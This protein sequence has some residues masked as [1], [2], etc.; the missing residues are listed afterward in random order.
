VSA[1]RIYHTSVSARR[2]QGAS[3]HCPSWRQ[4]LS[5]SICTTARQGRPCCLYFSYGDI[6]I[7]RGLET[8][9]RSHSWSEFE[10]RSVF[11]FFHYIIILGFGLHWEVSGVPHQFDPFH[12]HSFR[13][14]P[15]WL[16]QCPTW[17][18][19]PNPVYTWFPERPLKNTNLTTS[20]PPLNPSVRA[21]NG[22]Q[23]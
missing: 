4:A 7:Q 16:P 11:C 3:V 9:Q 12:L 17:P 23:Q 15:R 13:S 8:C 14:G 6:E 2:K 10:L 21:G 18:L 20:H 5:D 19:S 22:P 1:R